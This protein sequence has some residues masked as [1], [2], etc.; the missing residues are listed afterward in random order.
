MNT[1][2]INSNLLSLGVFSAL[3]ATGLLLAGIPA[4]AQTD[5]TPMNQSPNPINQPQTPINQSPSQMDGSQTPMNQ[6]PNSQNQTP[7]QTPQNTTPTNNPLGNYSPNQAPILS[8]G[9]RGQ[10]VRDVQTALSQQGLYNGPVDGIYG[11]QTRAAVL[12]FQRS[13]NLIADGIIGPRTWDVMIDRT[14]QASGL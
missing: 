4:N 13:R 1:K 7:V 3:S 11:P 5:S 8:Y 12:S 6:S 2:F 10:A 14:Q 9:S